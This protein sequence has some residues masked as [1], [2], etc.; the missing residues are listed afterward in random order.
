MR[1]FSDHLYDQL[2]E[3]LR[4]ISGQQ[5]KPPLRRAMD[6]VVAVRTIILQLK[7]FIIPYQFATPAEEIQFFKEIQPEF[8]SL[9][10][11]YIRVVYIESRQPVGS[12]ED[13][14]LYLEKELHHI[15]LF[16]EQN[17]DIYRYYRLE[18]TERDA[19]YFLRDPPLKHLITSDLPTEDA[20]LLY[21]SRFCTEAGYKISRIKANEMLRPYLEEK[22]DELETGRKKVHNP[23]NWKLKKVQL[24][25]LI[26]LL[27]AYG[28]FGNL[29]LKTI[30]DAIASMWNCPLS[31]I[32]KTFEE[33]RIRKKDRFPFT[34]QMLNAGE[35]KMDEDDINAR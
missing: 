24:A 27:H 16:F 14:R 18:E 33:M 32:Y 23:L 1:D 4:E 10:I 9:L 15:L 26:F 2:Q 21:D 35:R 13:Q 28:A 3:S 5:D 11:Y 6:S 20:Y 31:N 25:E 17:Q 12:K 7:E 30:V 8:Y 34:R 19:Q 22:L 29:K